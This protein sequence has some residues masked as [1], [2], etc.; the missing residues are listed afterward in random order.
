MMLKAIC[1]LLVTINGQ[2]VPC[3]TDRIEYSPGAAVT[4]GAIRVVPI[5]G[6]WRL[7]DYMPG[8]VVIVGAE[9]PVHRS[10]FE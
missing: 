2:P 4:I 5:A 3:T 7:V 8:R 9:V 6:P 10:G 1:A